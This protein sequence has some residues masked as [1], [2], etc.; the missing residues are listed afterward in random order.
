MYYLTKFD[1]VIQSGFWV[2]PKI[3]SANLCKPVHEIIT[4][5]TFICPFESGKF[6]KEGKKLQKSEYLKSGKSFLDE[7][8]NIFHSLEGYYLVK[9]IRNSGHEPVM[10][11]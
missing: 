11:L 3:T 4:Y 1:D 10:T 7:I 2:I 5:S 6:V 8:K 9:K